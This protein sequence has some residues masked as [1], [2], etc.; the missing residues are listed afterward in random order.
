MKLRKIIFNIVPEIKKG[1]DLGKGLRNYATSLMM[2]K[3]NIPATFH[4]NHPLNRDAL[5]LGELYGKMNFL[6]KEYDG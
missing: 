3:D 4:L 2:L 1:I 6:N 5:K